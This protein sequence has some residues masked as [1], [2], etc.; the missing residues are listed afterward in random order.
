MTE[1]FLKDPQDRDRYEID[2]SAFLGEDTVASS[3]WTVPPGITRT[4]ATHTETATTVW[5]EGGAHGQEYLAANA[6]TTAGGLTAER[7]IKI[8]VRHR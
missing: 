8:V 4:S 6:I 5:L 1:T 3:A 2:W 7:S